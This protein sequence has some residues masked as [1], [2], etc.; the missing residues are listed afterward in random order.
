MHFTS[1]SRLCFYNVQFVSVCGKFY[2][3]DSGAKSR[4]WEFGFSKQITEINI[5]SKVLDE[6]V[7]LFSRKLLLYRIITSNVNEVRMQKFH[8]GV[9]FFMHFLLQIHKIT[10]G[11]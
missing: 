2:K 5:S 6:L 7:S 8:S 11:R 4:L 9:T 1:L 10:F 3:I